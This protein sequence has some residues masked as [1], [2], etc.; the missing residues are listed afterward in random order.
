MEWSAKLIEDLEPAATGDET[1]LIM[2]VS[3]RY[4]LL[5]GKRKCQESSQ[6]RLEKKLT[7]RR[8]RA[9]YD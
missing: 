4:V 8:S 5:T 3:K 2:T 9:N 6:E 7:N 1:G